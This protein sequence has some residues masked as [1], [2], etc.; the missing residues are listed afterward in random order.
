MCENRLTSKHASGELACQSTAGCSSWSRGLGTVPT[1]HSSAQVFQ[2][3][4]PILRYLRC[5]VR[6]PNCDHLEA[7]IVS[8]CQQTS[9]QC[10]ILTACGWVGGRQSPPRHDEAFDRRS[11]LD[12]N[13][14]ME[15]DKWCDMQMR[16]VENRESFSLRCKLTR[17]WLCPWCAS[18]EHSVRI[19]RTPVR[20]LL[21]PCC[22]ELRSGSSQGEG[23]GGGSGVQASASSSDTTSVGLGGFPKSCLCHVVSMSSILS[24]CRLDEMRQACSD[25]C[26]TKRT[27]RSERLCEDG[28]TED[29]CNSTARWIAQNAVC[30]QQTGGLAL[31]APL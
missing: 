30:L 23:P 15:R 8:R 11:Y 13:E 16:K 9:L 7:S 6:G 21:A 19:R 5:P 28:E 14:M 2:K 10:A 29:L 22:G 27:K 24:R 26:D 4:V 31:E 18:V 12:F 3:P 17:R 1:V 25:A 20:C